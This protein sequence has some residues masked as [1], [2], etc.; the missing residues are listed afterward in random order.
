VN[1]LVLGFKVEDLP[2]R[3][4]LLEQCI[5]EIKLIPGKYMQQKVHKIST[6]CAE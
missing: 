1:L 3:N 4:G 6:R 2:I 5:E